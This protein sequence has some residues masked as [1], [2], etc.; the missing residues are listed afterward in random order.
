MWSRFQH[1]WA[2]QV[3]AAGGVYGRRGEED[4]DQEL[5]GWGRFVGGPGPRVMLST[6]RHSCEWG[7]AASPSAVRFGPPAGGIEVPPL[8][9]RLRLRLVVGLAVPARPPFAWLAGVSFRV[10]LSWP[11]E[12]EGLWDGEVGAVGRMEVTGH[13]ARQ[14]RGVLVPFYE[15]DVRRLPAGGSLPFVVTRAEVRPH[16]GPRVDVQLLWLFFCWDGVDPPP[17]SPAPSE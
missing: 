12:L 17:A 11:V 6:R 5:P 3:G 8:R 2:N 16:F 4:L 9:G 1:A 14:R 7:A 13:S 10:R 15:V